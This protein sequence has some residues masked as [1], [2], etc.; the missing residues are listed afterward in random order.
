MTG[1]K[2]ISFNHKII[3]N[4]K[5]R[6]KKFQNV[7][8]L[9]ALHYFVA[10]LHYFVA[11]LHFL[12][13]DIYILSGG[14]CPTTTST[15]LLVEICKGP[16]GAVSSHMWFAIHWAGHGQLTKWWGHS[17]D[18]FGPVAVQCANCRVVQCAECR[19][20][21]SVCRVQSKVV[22]VQSVE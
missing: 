18:M 16:T 9:T 1:G 12:F 5:R 21:W 20:R 4:R 11:A 15:E 17:I 13:A 22:S 19:V 14:D 8:H 10:L 3:I 2:T 7:N 6:R